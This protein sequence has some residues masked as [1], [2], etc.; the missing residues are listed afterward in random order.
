VTGGPDGRVDCDV[1]CDVP[2]RVALEPHLPE[3]WRAYLA[4]TE[5]REPPG[6]A[7]TYPSWSKPLATRGVTLE[8]VQEDVLPG[9]DAAILGCYYGLE[10]ETHPYLARD[11]ATAVNGWLQAEWLDRDDRLLASAVITPQ[12]TE[13]AVAEI[14]RI[15]PDKRFVQVLL[16]S[17]AWDPYGHQR[18]LPIWEAAARHGLALAITFG[19]TSGSPSSPVGWFGSHFEEYVY[20]SQVFQTHLA[21]MIAAGVFDR[22]PDLKVV[23]LES[24]WTWLPS[25]LWRMDTEWKAARRET[26]WVKELPSEYIRRHVRLTVQ[27]TDMPGST[28][29]LEQVV[30]QLGSEELLLWASDYPHTY[31]SSPDAL[32]AQLGETHA[33]NVLRENAMRT[34]GLEQRLPALAS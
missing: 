17:R 11:L 23:V 28:A 5:Y 13:S 3:H 30:E 21:S 2:S 25:C 26:P 12:F 4:E 18:Y 27:P 32:L 19:G 16:P 7:Y 22:F 15:G 20:A 29:H 14:E 31:G 9:A 34:Y 1:H 8:R 33:A 6:I 10:S 24:G